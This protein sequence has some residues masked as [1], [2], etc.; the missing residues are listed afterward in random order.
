[1]K[2][3]SNFR[4]VIWGI[5]AVVMIVAGGWHFIVLIEYLTAKPSITWL[6]GGDVRI[7]RSII[8]NI[9]IF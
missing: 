7:C 9:A 4:D 8:G 6:W 2:V 3:Q 5:I 1:M